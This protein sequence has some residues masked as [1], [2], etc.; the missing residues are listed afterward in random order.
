MADIEWLA[1]RP[2]LSPPD[3]LDALGAQLPKQVDE[4]GQSVE[5]AFPTLAYSIPATQNPRTFATVMPRSMDAKVD[6]R[7]HCSP[8]H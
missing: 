4:P 5:T 7:I 3:R 2:F 1:L 6:V 8:A